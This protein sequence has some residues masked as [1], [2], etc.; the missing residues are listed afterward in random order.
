MKSYKRETGDLT[1]WRNIEHQLHRLDGPALEYPNGDK[2]W[3]QYGNFHRQG[4]P[5][6]E[7]SG[8]YK[9]WWIR[10]H[11]VSIHV[12][13]FFNDEGIEPDHTLVY[14]PIR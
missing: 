6:L 8:G 9:E 13:D 10:G 4:G 14:V 11:K 12:W 5:A 2:Y 1:E 7:Y 3:Y